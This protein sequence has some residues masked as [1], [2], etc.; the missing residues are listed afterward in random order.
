LDKPDPPL[1][2]ASF[3]SKQLAPEKIIATKYV[4]DDP[5]QGVVTRPLC[6]HPQIAVYTGLATRTTPQISFAVFR[7]ISS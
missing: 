5:S 3:E 1:C 2:A 6:P 4:N 7:T